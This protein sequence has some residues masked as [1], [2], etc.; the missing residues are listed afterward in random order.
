MRVCEVLPGGKLLAPGFVVSNRTQIKNIINGHHTVS[1]R[2]KSVLTE[3]MKA[4]FATEEKKNPIYV[5]PVEIMLLS[6]VVFLSGRLF[7]KR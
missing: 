4:N 2:G 7:K 3:G 1:D 5:G 6:V